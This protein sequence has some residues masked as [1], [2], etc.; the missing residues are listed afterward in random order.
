MQGALWLGTQADPHRLPIEGELQLTE[1]F[2]CFHL[3]VSG[4]KMS[5]SLGNFFTGD[6]LLDEK[7]Y[8]AEQIRYYLSLLGLPEKQS[9]FDFA[10]LDDRNKFLAGPMN[11]AFERPTAA[12]LSKF[13][14]KV[15]EGKLLEKVESDTVRIVQR[16]VKAME[17]GDYPSLLFDIENYARIINSLFTQWK[18]HDDRFP[19]AERADALYSCFYVLKN[20]IILLHPFV[21]ETTDRVRESLRLPKSIFRLTELGTGIPA[22]HEIGPKGRYFPSDRNES[23]A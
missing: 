14:G 6:Q 17:R 7:G 9:D 10:K 4:E 20:L 19:E 3:L 18:P 5:K 23:E 2:G 8:E 1:I 11:A 22:G 15:P 21:P 16:Y 13:D 12:A